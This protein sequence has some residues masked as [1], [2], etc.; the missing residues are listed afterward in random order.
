MA[1]NTVPRDGRPATI[2]DGFNFQGDKQRAHWS[3]LTAEI[4]K[5][6]NSGRLDL[7]P[8]SMAIGIEHDDS[9]EVTGVV[10]VDAEGSEQRQ[11]ARAV[12][13]ACNA[14]ET[15]RLLLNSE[16]SLFP[17]G[18]A[19][20]SGQVG[21]NYIRHVTGSVYATFDRPVRMYRGETMAGIVA[22]ES[23]NDPGRG[24]VGGYSMQLFSL[25]PSLL[26]RRLIPGAW[27]RDFA[28]VMEQY[29]HMAGMWLLG[30]DI[31]VADAPGAVAHHLEVVVGRQGRDPVRARDARPVLGPLVVGLEVRQADRPVEEAGALDRPV[32]GVDP[33]LPVLEARAAPRPVHGRAPNR[34]T[35]PGGPVRGVLG[36]PDESD[37]VR[38]S[39]HEAWLNA[40]RLVIDEVLR[41]VVLASFEQDDLDALLAELI[42]ER[43]ATRAGADHDDHV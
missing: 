39:S 38:S 8:E 26:A 2:Q 37:V 31:L 33:E 9:G 1:I 3:T 24:F 19:N 13:V 28:E 17:D 30:E 40:A 6:E 7:R 16:S 21:R 29:D 10:Y 41:L 11:K 20:S 4:P 34:L 22:D 27:G 36:V 35:R 32:F 43:P 14:I 23:R 15:A 42:G 5:A 25:G 12:C 18:L